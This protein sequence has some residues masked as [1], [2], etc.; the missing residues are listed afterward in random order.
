LQEETLTLQRANLGADHPDTLA[1]MNHL[2]ESYRAAGRTREAFPLLEE[3]LRRSVARLGPTDPE[4][5]TRRGNLARA[6]IEAGRGAEAVPHFAGFIAVRRQQLGAGT[7]SLAWLLA[8]ISADLLDAGQPA[9]AEPYLR[10]SLAIRDKLEPDLWTT[11]D[12]RALLGAAL[13]GQ[14]KG[15]EGVPLLEVGYHGL[16]ARTAAIPAALRRPSL[17]RALDHL[18]RH[19]EEVGPPEAAARWRK[20]RAALPPEAAPPPRPVVPN[21]VPKNVT[22]K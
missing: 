22:G 15:A 14:G 3:C 1:N 12:T 19:A 7:P 6:Y 8:R 13:L 16:K 18:V 5:T 4:T 2:G 9:A 21:N 10:E 11:F 17:A 20:E